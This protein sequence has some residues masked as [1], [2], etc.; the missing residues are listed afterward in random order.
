ML[1]IG[2]DVGGTNTDAVLMDDLKVVQH[3]KAGTTPDVMSGVLSALDHILSQGAIDRS[4]VAAVMIGTTH[5]TNAVIERKRLAPVGI[6]R[7]C[8]PAS[9]SIPPLTAWPTDLVEKLACSTHLVHGG[10]EYDGRILSEL[11]P[12]EVRE[13]A[14]ACAKAGIRNFAVSG[15]FSVVND[16]QERAAE[17]LIHEVVP[18][19]RVTLSSRLG[20]IGLLEREN[21][22]IL[23]AALLDL[24][25]E[26]VEA[27]H[28]ALA[29]AGILAPFYLTQNDGTLLTVERAKNLP[30]FT[31]ASGPTNSMQGAAFLSGVKDA[32]V[33]DIGG[34]TA[35]VGVL[36]NG[37]PRPASLDVEIGGVRTNFRMPDVYSIGLGGGSLVSP[38]GASVGPQSV[39]YRLTQEALVFGGSTLTATDIAVA[40]GRAK[41]GDAGKVANVPKET[42]SKALKAID[43]KLYDAI[44][45]M[46]TSAEQKTVLL[47]GGGSILTT[48]KVG[49]LDAQK[50]AHFA[51]ANAVGAA[52][53]QVSGEAESFVNLD[54]ENRDEAVARVTEAAKH[55]ATLAG[56]KAVT[57]QVIDVHESQVSYTKERS[58]RLRVRVAGELDLATQG[59]R[60]VS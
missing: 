33:V 6:L 31:C 39:G 51:V 25:D 52:I 56:A 43:T 57:L 48:E 28:R 18:G 60:S 46:R 34:T 8:L 29:R 54:K 12:D 55:N 35:D 40:G 53:A 7:I 20:R 17:A 22:T 9:K 13:A 1:R 16:E 58:V 11:Q 42:V 30:I 14:K 36:K 49:N 59:K 3:T 37:F 2:I 19:A 45:R 38:D 5:F 26:M 10:F 50:P 41:I 4:K 32:V 44:D 15:V 27:F 24:A 23:N 21:A 47:V